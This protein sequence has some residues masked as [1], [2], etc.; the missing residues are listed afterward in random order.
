MRI[1]KQHN[2]NHRDKSNETIDKQET[3][4]GRL[5]FTI[6]RL[7]HYYDSVNNK[8]AV[9]LALNTFLTGGIVTIMASSVP[10]TF[11]KD[12]LFVIT[13]FL[14]I[15]FGLCSLTILALTSIPFLSGKMQSLYY[16]GSISSCSSPMFH[17]LSKSRS[18]KLDLKDLREQTYQL[19]CGLKSKFNNLRNAGLLLIVQFI[20]LLPFFFSL[21]FNTYNNGNI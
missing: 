15:F 7:D 19:S 8:S 16:F 6:S 20:L 1:K 13:G 18:R 5:Q 14:L 11:P 10:F 3:E 17:A 2:R 21:I 4:Y 9:Y 12:L